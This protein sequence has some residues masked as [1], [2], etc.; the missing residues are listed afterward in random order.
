M[1]DK[2]AKFE[3][4]LGDS[5]IDISVDK[6]D[7][8]AIGIANYE[9]RQLARK[10]E[11]VDAIRAHDERRKE[12]RKLTDEACKAMVVGIR[13]KHIQSFIRAAKRLGMNLTVND[14]YRSGMGDDEGKIVAVRA[15]VLRKHHHYHGN[16]DAELHE[17]TETLDP[18]DEIVAMREEMETIEAELQD[19]GREMSE[20]VSSLQNLSTKE[21]E[22]RAHLAIKALEST[23]NGQAILDALTSD[24][25][26]PF[27]L[28]TDSSDAE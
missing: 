18:T 12:L 25:G 28:L 9:Q 14:S 6:E 3:L 24:A 19:M 22:V 27:A 15:I 23:E 4:T 10:K 17:V 7:L 16:M 1:S 2:E 11:L 8:L 26:S 5:K 21:R 13:E 20:I